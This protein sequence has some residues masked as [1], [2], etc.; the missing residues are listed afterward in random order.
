MFFIPKN[1]HSQ[2]DLD[3]LNRACTAKPR[4]KLTDANATGL[5]IAIVRI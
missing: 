1:P 3:T 4:D 2:E 5:S